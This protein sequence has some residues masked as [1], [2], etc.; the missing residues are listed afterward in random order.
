MEN[1]QKRSILD[2]VKGEQK[3]D[4]TEKTPDESYLHTALEA[5]A[6][7]AAHSIHRKI[8]NAK[9]VFITITMEHQP[10][11]DIVKGGS[12]SQEYGTMNMATIAKYYGEIATD[13]LKGFTS[14]KREAEDILNSIE[15][16]FKEWNDLSVKKN[17]GKKPIS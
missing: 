4:R 8:P 2:N 3:T 11:D 9:G 16:Q 17:D 7:V 10:S 14:M 6:A 5:A 12:F 15:T 13:I 1:E